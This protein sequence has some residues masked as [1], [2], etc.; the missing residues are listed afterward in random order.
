MTNSFDGEVVYIVADGAKAKLLRHKDGAF[1]A[2]E[3]LDAQKAAGTP[4]VTSPGASPADR[5]KDAFARVVAD[6]L[7]TLAA[8]GGALDGF[9]LAAPAEAL[10]EIREHLSK[11]AQAKILKT[12]VKDL[13]NIPQSQLASHFDIPETG[14]KSA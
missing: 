14:W 7:N 1:S 2:I 11:P 3:T 4:G 12:L 8:Y 9:V 13:V 5:A 6:R 10:H